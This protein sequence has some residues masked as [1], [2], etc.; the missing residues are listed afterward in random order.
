VGRQARA[1]LWTDDFSQNLLLALAPFLVI[2][3][4]SVRVNRIGK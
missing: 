2:G 4:L 1:Q 3:A